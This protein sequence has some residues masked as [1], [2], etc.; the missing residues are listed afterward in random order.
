MPGGAGP[1]VRAARAVLPLGGRRDADWAALGPAARL[2]PAR[3]CCGVGA[4]V[5]PV[6]AVGALPRAPAAGRGGVDG[7]PGRA[8][9]ISAQG[10]WRASLPPDASVR[11][12][13]PR[14][15]TPAWETLFPAWVP[16]SHDVRA[17][18][19]T[20]GSLPSSVRNFR[21]DRR[22][23]FFAATTPEAPIANWST[24]HLRVCPGQC[25]QSCSKSRV[26]TCRPVVSSWCPLASSDGH[27]RGYSRCYG[28]SARMCH[29]RLVPLLTTKER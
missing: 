5:G 3:G 15:L 25:H 6:G 26:P 12:Q 1:A 14:S 18:F 21:S 20:V 19:N 23:Q 24:K 28:P 10:A 29:V 2:Q 8:T 7:E 22:F 16:V 13:C 9:P 17:P 27:K 4:L 11:V